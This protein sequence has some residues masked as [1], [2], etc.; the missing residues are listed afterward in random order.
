MDKEGSRNKD[1]RGGV[2]DTEQG[3]KK[4]EEMNKRIEVKEWREHFM[5][6]LGGVKGRVLKGGGKETGEWGARVGEE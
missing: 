5:T 4:V 6:L 3:K 2:E 1:G